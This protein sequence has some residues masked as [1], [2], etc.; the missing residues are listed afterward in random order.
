MVVQA[1]GT[2]ARS[3][4]STR[5]PRSS[6]QSTTVP[7]SSTSASAARRPRRSSARGRLR[8][9][10]GSPARR[11]GR[12]RAMCS[13]TR[14]SIP[15]HC[16]S[17]SARAASAGAA[18]RSRPRR[19]R[20]PGRASRA[21]ARTSPSRRP[22]RRLQRHL[23]LLPAV[24]LSAQRPPGLGRRRLRLRQRHLVRRAPGRRSRRARLGGEP[25][26]RAD[27]VA[28]VLEADGIR[29][30]QLEP[31]LGYGVLDV[32]AAVA[33]A[34]VTPSVPAPAVVRRGPRPSASSCTG[35]ASARASPSGGV[36][37]GTSPL[38]RLTC[39][40]GVARSAF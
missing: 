27:E 6:T 15:R 20:A 34:Q 13:A 23:V 10:E 30:R 37:R 24:E 2:A 22:A 38:P 35:S 25:E 32:A 28:S 1:G 3:R 33:R 40:R 19:A 17:P 21:R 7:G 12:Q 31:R 8:G 39:D 5:R 29:P 11:R 36:R 18:S 14:S 16:S 4:T 26:L 9:L